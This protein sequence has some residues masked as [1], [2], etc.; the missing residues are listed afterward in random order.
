MALSGATELP[1]R[2]RSPRGASAPRGR[3]PCPPAPGLGLAFFPPFSGVF[4]RSRARRRR[5]KPR[6]SDSCGLAGGRSQR[7][8]RGPRS[9]LSNVTLGHSIGSRRLLKKTKNPQLFNP[10]GKPSPPPHLSSRPQRQK[11]PV[12]SLAWRHAPPGVSRLAH[13][14]CQT[15]GERNDGEDVQNKKRSVVSS[16]CGN[17]VTEMFWESRVLTQ[18][19]ICNWWKKPKRGER[20]K[21][22]GECLT[23]HTAEAPAI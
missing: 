17:S 20:P 2:Q 8:G 3:C 13:S 19:I 10:P 15:H 5:E 22:L 21:S 1:W 4:A 18:K 14:A 12:N 11:A 23:E 16:S 6:V 7:M 9:V